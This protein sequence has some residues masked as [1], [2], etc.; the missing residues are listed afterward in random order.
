VFEIM[1][2][3]TKVGICLRC[4]ISTFIPSAL[5]YLTKIWDDALIWYFDGS[6]FLYLYTPKSCLRYFRKPSCA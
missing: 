1:R 2:Q 5:Y 6:N 4:S 3:H